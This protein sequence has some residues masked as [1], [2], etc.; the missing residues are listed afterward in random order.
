MKK[1]LTLLLVS[2]ILLISNVSAEPLAVASNDSIQS[3]LAAH[4]GQQVT[5]RLKSGSELTGKVGEVNSEVVHLIELSGMEYFDG[6]A[7]VKAIEAV[8]IRTK[9]K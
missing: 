8:V 7:S 1:Y 4:K 2:G 9:F 5:V 6:V 3:I